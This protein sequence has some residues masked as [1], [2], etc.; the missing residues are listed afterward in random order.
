MLAYV[1][2]HWPRPELDPARYLE[3]LVAFHRALEAEPPPGFLGS[4][5]REV[6]GAPWVPAP[7]AVE[8]WY[9]VSD[10]AALGA[11]EQA[12]VAGGRLEP[13]DRAARLAL[14]GAGGVYGRVREGLA[15]PAAATWFAKP[16]GIPS[17]A[18]LAGIPEGELWQ[19]RL[20]LG[21]APEFCLAAGAAPPGAE[22]GAVTL[23]VR[24]LHASR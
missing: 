24:S 8:D 18:F 15:D 14:G 13:H 16:A 20:V 17:P 19:R 1:F 9:L 5:V 3:A 23:G 7:R 6:S 12:A 2:W 10:F 22:R 4:R 11:L 21:P